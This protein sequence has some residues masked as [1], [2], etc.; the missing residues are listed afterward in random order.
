MPEAFSVMAW[1][2]LAMATVGLGVMRWRVAQTLA[3]GRERWEGRSVAIALA[4][5]A[6]AAVRFAW[7][8]LSVLLAR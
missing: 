1:S 8:P 4:A 3:T 2:A 7:D 5:V 6:L